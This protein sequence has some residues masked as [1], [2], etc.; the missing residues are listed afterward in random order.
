MLRS[1]PS[2]IFLPTFDESS[3]RETLELATELRES[4]FSLEWYPSP[5]KL[6]KQFKYADRQGIPISVI[7]GPEEIQNRTVTVK[8]MKSGDQEIIQR[9]ELVSYLKKLN[10]EQG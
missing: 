10:R 1:N 6:S 9:D 8:K 5:V 2:Q 7:L 4:G 3:R